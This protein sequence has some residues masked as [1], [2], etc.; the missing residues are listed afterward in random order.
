M[1]KLPSNCDKGVGAIGARKSKIHQRD[2]RSMTTKFSYRL[3]AIRRVG[4]EKHVL[5]RADDRSQSLAEHRMILYAQDANRF[6]LSHD[7]G[8]ASNCN[9]L[10]GSGKSLVLRY[11]NQPVE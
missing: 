11:R 7:K 8:L 5:L 3:H 4:N 10:F 2:V 9:G 6:G 1:W